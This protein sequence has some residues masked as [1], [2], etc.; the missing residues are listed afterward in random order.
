[1]E[2]E[3]LVTIQFR[4]SQAEALDRRHLANHLAPLMAEAVAAGGDKVSI[5]LQPYDPDEEPD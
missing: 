4:L 1:M 3:I 2:P 5:S